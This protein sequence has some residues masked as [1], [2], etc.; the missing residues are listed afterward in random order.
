MIP[1]NPQNDNFQNTL[2]EEKFQQHKLMTNDIIIKLNK[3]GFVKQGVK[4][5]K[6]GDYLKFSYQEHQFTKEQRNKLKGA[7]F[8]KFRFCPMCSWRR[9]KNITGQLNE[10]L[11]SIEADRSI[12]YLFLTLTIQN[13]KI[14]DLKATIKLMN[15]AFKRMSKTKAYKETVIGHFKALEL[16]GD[17]TKEGEA[18]P[19]FHI[20][21]IVSNSYFNGNYYISQD[22]WVEMWQKALRVDYKPVVDVR[23]I[24][25]KKQSTFTALQS[26]VFEVAKYAVKHSELANRS[27]RDFTILVNQTFKMRF[28]ST[29]GELKKKMNLLKADEDLINFKEETEALWIEIEELI[30]KWQNGNYYLK[31]K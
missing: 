21:L 8:C 15:E 1:K 3:N 24:R 20:L 31:A 16:L 5:L 23:R 12:S 4:T 7:D 25:P 2:K 17:D 27:D 6:C 13:P 9:T 28:F 10:A 14:E 26:A 29:G 22:K 19:H 11:E 18:H 30:Y